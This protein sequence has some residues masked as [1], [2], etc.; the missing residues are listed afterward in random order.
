MP[1]KLAQRRSD[2]LGVAYLN[3]SES[4]D[5][6]MALG[7]LEFDEED[8]QGV[9]GNEHDG[10]KEGEGVVT[11][12]ESVSAGTTKIVGG[13][14]GT[15]LFITGT[16]AIAEGREAVSLT[17]TTGT[18]VIEGGTDAVS[19]TVATMKA[20]RVAVVFGTGMTATGFE[21][22]AEISLTGTII[23]VSEDEGGGGGVVMV[24]VLVVVAMVV[25]MEGV[26]VEMV[27]SMAS[28]VVVVMAVVGRSVNSLLRGA[29]L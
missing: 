15:V 29:S 21:E 5:A 28:V 22:K 25:L 12:V 16:T 7:M 27:A 2:I 19:T 20:G 18:T 17:E 11:S 9:A 4:A 13:D 3:R 24:V 23:V 26:E 8:R 14:T 1:A 10:D 6:V